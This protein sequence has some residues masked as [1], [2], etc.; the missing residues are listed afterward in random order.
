MD[1]E[2]FWYF[3][4]SFM[5]NLH[6]VDDDEMLGFDELRGR[7]LQWNRYFGCIV[8]GMCFFGYH[9]LLVNG[10]THTHAHTVGG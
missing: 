9:F 7:R 3:E 5:A 10:H 1:F 6:N 4:V 8:V 2:F